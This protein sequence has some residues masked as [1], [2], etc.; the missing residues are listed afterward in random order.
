MAVVKPNAHSMKM[1]RKPVCR[2]KKGA[3]KRREQRC[4]GRG[5]K[6][7]KGG[8]IS[9]SSPD[10]FAILVP[11]KYSCSAVPILSFL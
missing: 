7:E 8:V 6:K 11:V 4:H 1:Q 5:Q 10:S 9:A 2:E 3:E